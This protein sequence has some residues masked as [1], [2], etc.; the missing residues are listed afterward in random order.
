M[1]G[2][3]GLTVEKPEEKLTD[4][5][6]EVLI[7]YLNTLDVEHLQKNSDKKDA[8]KDLLL[9]FMTKANL[10]DLS[11]YYLYEKKDNLMGG[12]LLEYM[13]TL[14]EG[15]GRHRRKT[16]RSRKHKRRSTRRHH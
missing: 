15:G 12:L 8:L 16:K 6:R 13:I 9:E 11:S 10:A 3:S 7:K 4:K 2:N 14:R 5:Q 1:S